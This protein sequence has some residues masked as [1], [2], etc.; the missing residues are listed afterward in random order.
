MRGMR[1][2]IEEEK[3]PVRINAVAP[4]W[5]QTGVVPEKIMNDLGVKTQPPSV[6]ARGAALLMADDTRKAHLLRIDQGRYDEIDEAVLL[7]TYESLLREGDVL[8]DTTLL[9]MMEAMG[10]VYKDKV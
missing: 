9:R 3:L 7:P 5:T 4:S 10:G 2:V 6:V 8:E 1:Q